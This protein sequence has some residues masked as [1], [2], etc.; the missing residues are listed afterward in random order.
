MG[1][2]CYSHCQERMVKVVDGEQGGVSKQEN[3]KGG[4]GFKFYELAEPLLVKNPKLPV[5]Q[6]NPSYTFD[7]VAE[8]ICKIEG[9]TYAPQGEFHGHSSENRFIHIT[10][11]FVNTKYIQSLMK[12]LG[13]SQSLLIYC[14]RMQGDMNLSVNVEV[15]RIPKDL[16]SKCSFEGDNFECSISNIDFMSVEAGKRE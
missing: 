10:M 2:H 15:R 14:K 16:L 8:A 7:M 11:E 6:I 9:F 12:N 5:Y 1:S 4:G 13:E 3:W